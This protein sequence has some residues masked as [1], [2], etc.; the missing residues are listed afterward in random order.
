MQDP[1][2]IFE[3]PGHTTPSGDM[4]KGRSRDV[5]GVLI[6]GDAEPCRSCN[7]GDAAFCLR[8]RSVVSAEYYCLQDS[9][10][11]PEDLKVH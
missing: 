5:A 4:C 11:D 10:G 1:G 7:F 2:G 6:G 3:P 8:G 9:A